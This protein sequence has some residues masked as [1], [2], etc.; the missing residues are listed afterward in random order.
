MVNKK[1]VV[2]LGFVVICTLFAANLQAA[3]QWRP[4]FGAAP[5]HPQMQQQ[6]PFRPVVPVNRYYS[7][8]QQEMRGNYYRPAPLP[9]RGPYWSSPP[10]VAAHPGASYRPP[11]QRWPAARQP[12]PQQMMPMYARQ[13]GWRPAIDPRVIRPAPITQ[14]RPVYQPL[15]RYAGG[16]RQF[17]PVTHQLPAGQGLAAGYR[18]VAPPVHYRQPAMSFPV[19]PRALSA[20][21]L[22]PVYPG[23][24]PHPAGSAANAYATPYSY[25]QPDNH[26]RVAY[27]YTPGYMPPVSYW[28][29][30]QPS[31]HY[32]AYYPEVNPYHRNQPNNP[33]GDQQNWWALDMDNSEWQASCYNCVE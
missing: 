6:L 31:Y 7:A 18:P 2:F 20:S 15:A 21:N 13:Y 33:W 27:Q 16:A 32:P 23:Y 9:V 24:L 11:L 17:R 12:S 5:G 14:S 22:P 3:S 28:M 30:P 10:V 19:S 25:Y 8:S 4:V 1:S 29:R 26:G